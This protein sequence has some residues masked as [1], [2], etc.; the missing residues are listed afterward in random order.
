MANNNK[1]RKG[2]SKTSAIVAL[3]VVLA[4]TVVCGVLGFTGMALPPRGQYRISSWLP[5]ADTD[6]WPQALTLGLDLRGGVYVEYSAQKVEDIEGTF[7][8]LLENTVAVITRRLTDKGYASATVQKINGNSGIRVEVPEVSNPQALLDLIGTPAELSFRDPNG[9]EFMTGKH[10]QTAQGGQDPDSGEFVVSFALTSEGAQLFAEKTRSNIGRQIS[11]Y[12]DNE[13]LISPTVQTA[14]TDGRGIINGMGTLER[15]QTIAA[16]IQS[17]ALP[18]S[19]TQQKVDT[20]SATLGDTALSTSVLAAFIGILLIMAFM[21][22]R[23]RLNGVV[24]SWALCIYIIVLFFL[25][26]A[27]PGIQLTLPGLA[28]IVLGIGM[29]VDA[30]VIIY[31]RF[32]EELRRGRPAKGAARAGFKNA[33]SAILDAN[34]TTMIAG[35]VLLF[36]GTGSVQGFATTLLLGVLV[37]MLTAVVV[38]RFLMTRFIAAGADKPSLFCKVSGEPSPVNADAAKEEVQ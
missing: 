24:A 31:E 9:V 4:L 35:F 20:V 14:I 21:I 34:V 22:F 6:N 26:A 1:R 19:L 13:L 36:L 12:L 16:Q 8:Q 2:P 23:Y 33:L 37:S 17:G 38:T 29:A 3:C 25:L 5:T 30:N 15:A 7:D 11:I 32:N 18:L 28:G 10:V 27:L